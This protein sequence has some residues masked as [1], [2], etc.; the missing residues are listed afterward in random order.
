MPEGGGSTEEDSAERGGE[1]WVEV[2]RQRAGLH[3]GMNEKTN[4]EKLNQIQCI[5]GTEQ[6]NIIGQWYSSGI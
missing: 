1:K 2:P 5:D 4:G 3:K 6:L